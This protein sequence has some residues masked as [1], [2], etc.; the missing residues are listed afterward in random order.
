MKWKFL[1]LTC[2][3]IAPLSAETIYTVPQGYTKVS[4]A[5]GSVADGPKLTAISATLLQ[6][7]EFSGPV[8]IGAFT[9]AV[10][11]GPD[12]Q[13]ATV[14]GITWTATRWTAEPH[15]A[16]L[17]LA[18]DPGNA[19]GIPPAE[20]AFLILGNTPSGG[21]TLAADSDLL[22]NFP[23]SSTI[24]IRKANTLSSL[25]ASGAAGIDAAD[26]VFI[27]DNGK[28]GGPGWSSFRYSSTGGGNWV[29]ITES[30]LANNMVVFPDEG[31]FVQRTADTDLILTLFG[32]VP[33]AP[34]VGSV[35]GI[36]FL[37]SR[38]PMNTELQ[39]LGLQDSSWQA[40]DR[41]YIWNPLGDTP[42]WEAHRYSTTGGGI[43]IDIL[44]SVPSSSKII[45]PSSAVFVV[46][47]NGVTPGN[48]EVITELPYDPFGE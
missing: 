18:D 2:T 1:F 20:K 33:A 47:E 25:F 17:T 6:D 37:S 27:W 14:E 8:T 38:V 40:G 16:Y 13:A 48:G 34:Q 10:D 29:N 45:T 42:R 32:E 24:K 31:L 15:L 7:V 23:V 3:L 22:A 5:A 30:S 12:T 4:V 43:W 41:V 44:N 36:G 11:P 9:D 21:L 35:E 39:N 46:R 26:R 28:D 19:D